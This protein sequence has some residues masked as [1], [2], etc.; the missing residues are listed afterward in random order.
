MGGLL[1]DTGIRRDLRQAGPLPV[2]AHMEMGRLQP[3][4]PIE[5]LGVLPLLRPVQQG[6]A[7]PLGVRRPRKRRLPPQ[8]RLDQ[9]HPAPDRQARSVNRRSRAERILDPATAQDTPADQPD[10]PAATRRPERPVPHLQG[11]A[12]R[13]RATTNH[14]RVGTM[15]AQRPHTHHRAGARD[16]GPRWLPSD[17]RRLPHPQPPGT[18]THQDAHGA[19]LSRMLGNGHVR[20]SGGPGAARRPAYPTAPAASARPPGCRI[21]PAVQQSPRVGSRTSLDRAR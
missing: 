1:P 13:R 10:H 9:H 6:P 7:G 20:F 19:C 14:A 2:A 21:A 5:A 16:A 17:P 11:H 12:L 8:V 15:A 4:E 3:P 18:S